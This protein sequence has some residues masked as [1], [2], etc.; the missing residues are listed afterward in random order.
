MK[1]DA[2]LVRDARNARTRLPAKDWSWARIL[3]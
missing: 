1:V 2:W 3:R